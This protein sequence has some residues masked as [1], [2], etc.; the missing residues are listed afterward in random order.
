[1]GHPGGPGGSFGFLVKS[2][3]YMTNS[4]TIAVARPNFTGLSVKLAI[5]SISTVSLQFQDLILFNS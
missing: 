4:D 5:V 2:I 1:M 3:L